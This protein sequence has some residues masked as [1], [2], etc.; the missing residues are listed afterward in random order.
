MMEPRRERVRVYSVGGLGA[1]VLVGLGGVLV[2][3][4]FAQQRQPESPT[5]LGTPTLSVTTQLVTLDITVNDKSGH[6]VFDL[7][8]NDFTVRE[9][10]VPQTLRYF[11]PPSAHRMPSPG[12]MVRF[13]ADL[14]KIGDAPVSLLVLDEIN[15]PFADMALARSALD[16]YLK[17]QPDV[18]PEPTALFFVDNKKLDVIQDYTQNKA[19]LQLALKKHFPSYP[20]QLTVNSGDQAMLPRMSRTFG[21]LVE[22]S[23]ATR[24]VR[25]R[26]NVIWVGKGFPSINITQ[27]NPDAVKV[28]TDAVKKTTF[29]LLQS[30]VSL[31]TI[32]PATLDTTPVTDQESDSALVAGDLNGTGLI[33][34][35]A[36][37][38]R[39][40]PARPAAMLFP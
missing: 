26:K 19:A 10:G 18:L 27:A 8:K 30:K 1:L 4:A 23:E 11:E 39:Q 32:D 37:S 35:G 14:S 16:R 33:F 22:I 40:W 2:Q 28:I 31:F 12:E 20:W 15:T 38:L 34:G 24:G 17:A 21:A 6:P 25:G 3:S 29:A 9:N 36:F 13:S 7:G 5:E